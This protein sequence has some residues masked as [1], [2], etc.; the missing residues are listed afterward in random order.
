MT[1]AR[2]GVLMN[3]SGKPQDAD[4]P[5]QMFNPLVW[6]ALTLPNAEIFGQP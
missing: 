5:Q 1:A 4:R 2:Q 6:F 3:R